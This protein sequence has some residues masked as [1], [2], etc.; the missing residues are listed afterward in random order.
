MKGKSSK[1]K[2]IKIPKYR[3]K[4]HVENVNK[5]IKESSSEEEDIGI[6]KFWGI[7]PVDIRN[8]EVK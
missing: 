1:E 7:S 2:E 4:N 6:R 8:K 5:E 3:R